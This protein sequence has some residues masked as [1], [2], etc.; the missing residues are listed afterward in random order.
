MKSRQEAEPLQLCGVPSSAAF[1]GLYSIF[2]KIFVKNRPNTGM[3]LT[4]YEH[5]LDISKLVF[6]ALN[7]LVIVTILNN[8]L[9]VIRTRVQVNNESK[10]ILREA[11]NIYN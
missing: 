5:A 11:K 8:P 10:G 4:M 3:P 1:W 6:S 2:S 9:S 7:A